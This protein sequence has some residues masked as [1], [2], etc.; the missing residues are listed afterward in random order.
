MD[1]PLA[2]RPAY[3][4][5]ARQQQKIYHF[6][7]LSKMIGWDRAAMMPPKGNEARAAAQAELDSHIHHLQTDPRQKGLLDAADAEP[8]DEVERANLREMRREW[9][10]ANAVPAELVE[11]Q[12]IA[13]AR[14]EHA[15]RTQR[16]ANDWK[17]FLPNLREVIRLA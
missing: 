14:C 11:A 4:E 3:A 5:L 6:H 1:T 17:G 2:T 8:L 13:A 16:K 10:L 12:T 9:H 7:H 15:W